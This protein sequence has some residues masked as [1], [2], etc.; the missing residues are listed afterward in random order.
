LLVTLPGA[1]AA[2]AAAAELRD[3]YGVG[4]TSIGDVE[5][6][7]GVVAVDDDGV[8]RALDPTG[9]DHFRS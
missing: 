4:L 8:E 1:S 3:A 5:A 7:D 9:W 6:G 2:A